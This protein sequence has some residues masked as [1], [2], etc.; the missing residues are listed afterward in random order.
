MHYL[1]FMVR[2]IIAVI[3]L[4]LGISFFVFFLLRLGEADATLAYVRLSGLVPTERTLAMV[5]EDLGLNL[6]LWQQYI[7]WLALAVQGDLGISYISGASAMQEVLSYIPATLELTL[8]AMLVTLVA[9]IPL[10]IIG[11]IYKDAWPDSIIRIFSFTAVSM[12]SY[13]LGFLLI[14]LFARHWNILPAMGNEGALS[15]ILPVATLAFMSLGI[16]ARLVRGAVLEYMHSRYV[17]YARARNVSFLR[18]WLHILRSV[19]IPVLTAL[20]MYFGEL[21]GGAV[22]VESIFNWPG[23]GKYI[24]SA[25]SNHDY[26]V[27]Q[28]FVLIMVCI[29]VLINLTVDMLYALIDP[30]LTLGHDKTRRTL[31]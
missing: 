16:N 2:R 18:I 28:S 8:W 26:P 21:L 23:V 7:E 3:P 19:S 4:L 20:S 5:R 9:S 29:F 13:W 6:P 1:A 22:I 31:P 27:I 15:F 30:R 11:A 10:G 17:V 24:I 25:I 14:F 12:P